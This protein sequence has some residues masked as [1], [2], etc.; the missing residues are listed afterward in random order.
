M[1]IYDYK[2]LIMKKK[3]RTFKLEKC[4]RVDG[5]WCE[6]SRCQSKTCACSFFRFRFIKLFIIEMSF[7]FFPHFICVSMNM[8]DSLGAMFI[9]A[10]RITSINPWM[11]KFPTWR[12]ALWCTLVSEQLCAFDHFCH[13]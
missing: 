7:L 9:A 5:R 12:R 4:R 6:D 13:I 3:P 11:N 1:V 2:F 8:E 10:D